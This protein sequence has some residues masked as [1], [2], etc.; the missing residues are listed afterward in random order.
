MLANKSPSNLCLIL[1][2]LSYDYFHTPMSSPPLSPISVVSIR[3]Q[4]LTLDLIMPSAIHLKEGQSRPRSLME[5]RWAQVPGPYGGRPSIPPKDVSSA[6]AKHSSSPPTSPKEPNNL[7]LSPERADFITV[8]DNTSTSKIFDALTKTAT[9][10]QND[11][12]TTTIL[13]A[14]SATEPTVKDN[15]TPATEAFGVLDNVKPTVSDDTSTTESFEDVVPTVK[16]ETYTTEISEAV[17]DGATTIKIDASTLQVLEA[18]TDTAST[19]KDYT[20]ITETTSNKEDVGTYVTEASMNSLPESA[21]P[22]TPSLRTFV[23][24]LDGVTVCEDIAKGRAQACSEDS[25]ALEPNLSTSTSSVRPP[26]VEDPEMQRPEAMVSESLVGT[27]EEKPE[28]HSCP[29]TGSLHDG[30]HRPFRLLPVEPP[31]NFKPQSEFSANAEFVKALSMITVGFS[32][33]SVIAEQR[34]DISAED[35]IIHMADYCLKSWGFDDAALLKVHDAALEYAEAT[36]K[37][38]EAR[39]MQAFAE[40]RLAEGDKKLAKMRTKLVLEETKEVPEE[41][42]KSHAFDLAFE[43]LKEKLGLTGSPWKQL[44]QDY[45]EMSAG[46][47]EDFM[48]SMLAHWEKLDPVTRPEDLERRKTEC[49]SRALE[50][51]ERNILSRNWRYFVCFFELGV[52]SLCLIII[53]RMCMKY[54]APSSSWSGIE[55][56]KCSGIACRITT[57]YTNE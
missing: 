35:F 12:S 54:G 45:D 50:L 24:D 47:V 3:E 41:R 2:F 22:L 7:R 25:F 57:R 16:G 19:V 20:S 39:Q 46:D 33:N 11:K 21:I 28:H 55:A 49:Q 51:P 27:E 48:D 42:T 43:E 37:A 53:C 5:S 1:M 18:V 32:V 15:S 56:R 4:I 44:M 17:A 31:S 9:T 52:F 38:A 26:H 6:E 36:K 23:V 30:R 14:V 29:G 40:K 8:K 34:P 13:E 10:V